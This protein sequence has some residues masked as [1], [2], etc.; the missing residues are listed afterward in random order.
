[1]LSIRRR[2]KAPCSLRLFRN[3]AKR[4]NT[5]FPFFKLRTAS[6]PFISTMLEGR[7]EHWYG[8]GLRRICYWCAQILCYF[9]TYLTLIIKD[10]SASFDHCPPSL[11]YDFR[12]LDSTYFFITTEAICG[13]IQLYKLVRSHATTTQAV[14]LATLHL[15]PTAP[16]ISIRGIVSHAGP[17]EANP[18][19][20]TPF[21]IHDDHRLHMFTVQYNH[22]MDVGE[23]RVRY[24][25]VFLHQRV[26]LM[27]ARRARMAQE[28]APLHIP[29]AEWG[30]LHT[31]VVFTS[32][33]HDGA[34]WRRWIYPLFGC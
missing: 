16:G 3:I 32:H 28:H 27:Y 17:V 26:L 6:L 22:P 13:A 11:E 20:H 18:L 1:M 23:H 7:H 9:A 21:T 34:H 12:L 10:T 5:P 29:W 24:V 30:P 15:P 4:M 31:R 8:T 14:H 25:N 33:P 19:P 2:S